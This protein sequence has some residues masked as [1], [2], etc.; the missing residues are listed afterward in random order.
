MI[1]DPEIF[2]MHGYSYLHTPYPP[3]IMDI[4]LM[5]YMTPTKVKVPKNIK[6]KYIPSTD[7]IKWLPPHNFHWNKCST[8]I[9]IQQ[10]PSRFDSRVR[11]VL[12]EGHNL[13][14]PQNYFEA[15]SMRFVK[16]IKIDA[17]LNTEMLRSTRLRVIFCHQ[18][19]MQAG[20]KCRSIDAEHVHLEEV[21][22]QLISVKCKY[23]HT[24]IDL[25][26]TNIEFLDVFYTNTISPKTHNVPNLTIRHMRSHK[27][28]YVPPRVRNL[29][30]VGSNIQVD[31][32]IYS[33]CNVY[34]YTRLNCRAYRN[35]AFWKDKPMKPS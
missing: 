23:L 22:D 10:L 14:L 21:S 2:V 3:H 1:H 24:N 11:E 33:Q 12:I 35:Y 32:D 30:L 20:D 9:S 8:C 27:I 17:D 7:K 34:I 13:K 15:C 26:Q 4:P 16:L 25:E 28:S 31:P 19:T 5:P 18:Y 29:R 6:S